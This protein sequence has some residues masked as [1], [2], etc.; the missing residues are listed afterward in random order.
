MS[1]IAAQLRGS[2]LRAARRS[3]V[4]CTV[5]VLIACFA[6]Q[7]DAQSASLPDSP[8]AMDIRDVK[9]NFAALGTGPM[10][11]RGAQPIGA[12]NIGTRMDELIVAAKL[13]LRMTYSPAMLPDLSHVRVSL[14]GQVLAALPLPRE[15]GGREIE[16]EVVLDARYFS[17]FNQIRFDLVGHY[18][19]E[20]ESEQHSSLWAVISPQ[21]ELELKI[22]TLELRND[23]ALLPAPF[24]DQRDNRRLELPVVLPRRP[25]RSMLRSAGIVASWFGALADYR[26]ARFPVSLDAL[27]DRHALV[28]MTNA[29][30]P[31]RLPVAD[32]QSPTISVIDHPDDPLAK[33]LVIQGRDDAQLLQAVE[34]LVLGTSVMSGPTAHISRVKYV[35]RAAYDAPRWLRSDRPVRFVELVASP[36]ELQ[37]SGISPPLITVTVRLPPD[38]FAWNRVGVPL[39]F[40]YRHTMTSESNNAQLLVSINDQLLRS[41]RLRP[42][43]DREPLAKLEIPLLQNVGLQRTDQLL[44]PAFQL[45]GDNQIQFQFTLERYR[46]GRC[47]EVFTDN[48][49]SA[50][51]PHS[52][53]DISTFSH[54]AALPDLALFANSGYPY[55]RYADLA[56]T[57]IVLP[58]PPSRES[59][60]Q[61]FFLLGRMG[62]HTG[63]AAVAYQLLDAQQ[64]LRAND[65]DLLILP[66]AQADRML[67]RWSQNLTLVM[68]R[69]AR[70]FREAQT[71]SVLATRMS[72]G[73]ARSRSEVNVAAT[74][75]LGA[76][77]GFESPLSADRSVVALAATDD[78]AARALI[79]SLEDVGQVQRIRGDLA[80][81]RAGIVQSY[82][83]DSVYYVGTLP[84]WNRLLFHL[85]RLPLLL[86]IVTLG[87]A[88]LLALW[89]HGWLKRRAALRLGNLQRP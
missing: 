15:Q 74:G 31:A 72:G 67:S 61:L 26:S 44:I 47:S 85:S 63:V 79:D 33:L 87:V 45:A 36:Q 43:S 38:L 1:R 28:F 8:A 65:L 27:P 29:A 19:M 54:Y 62:R 83:G 24:F 32:V 11:L 41:Y 56:E 89:I 77:I 12:V 48:S 30:R 57:A 51:D 25:S 40:R 49:R 58:N 82:Q 71:A 53:L 13:R 46:R 34:G 37:V 42:A 69:N 86:A 9:L 10:E 2:K 60:E 3:F 23:L 20:C 22:R 52:T 78:A 76:L 7:A 81:V 14:N 17:E 4:G 16:R 59:I 75:S 50:I 5:A 70:N 21:S 55:T 88:I 80:I 66:G 84:W 68:E 6:E 64:V 73:V 39:D 35:R 18:T